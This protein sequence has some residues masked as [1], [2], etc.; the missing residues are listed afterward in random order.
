MAQSWAINLF[1]RLI[2]DFGVGNVTDSE[3][4][5]FLDDASSELTTFN[6]NV[7]A[8]PVYTFDGLARDYQRETTYKAAINWWWD[9][10]AKLS[11]HH[12]MSLGSATQNVSEKWDRAM[13]MIGQLEIQYQ[14]IA[15]LEVDITHG[16]LSRYSKQT[17]RRIGGVDE[18]YTNP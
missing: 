18:E 4:L 10:A 6:T 17:L 15:R 16:N 12:S 1:R 11:D 8:T 7:Y 3:A 5:S 9:Y 13:Q 14:Q 2:G